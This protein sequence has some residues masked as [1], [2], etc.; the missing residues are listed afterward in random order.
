[1]A[2]TKV[3]G[4]TQATTFYAN[5]IFYKVN[6]ATSPISSEYATAAQLGLRV[7]I[8]TITIS[9]PV[10]EFDF[11]SIPTDRGFKRLRGIGYTRG[12]VSAT[13]DGM[14][15]IFNSDTT[16]TNYYRTNVQGLNTSA[17]AAESA[18]PI[19]GFT[20]GSTAPTDCYGKIEFVIE[21]YS[22]TN[23]VKD[24]WGFYGNY[25]T[26]DSELNV[27]MIFMSHDSLTDAITRVRLRSDNHGTDHLIGQVTL[28][29]EF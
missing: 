26:V 16:I 14:Y 1:M 5:D 29:G 21:N 2:D 7:P 25:R 20:T 17:T 27:G 19:I 8:E 23:T 4:L 12:T 22:N 13:N 10:G 28:Y 15:L 11:T 9:S 6:S 24:A 18:A 3:S